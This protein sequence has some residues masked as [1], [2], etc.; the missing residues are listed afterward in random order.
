MKL[1]ASLTSPYARK[2]RVILHEKQLP[3]E[4]VV[5]SPWESNTLIP[6]VNPLGKVPVL[7]TDDEEVY[8]DSPLIAAWLET[9]DAPP[10]L[11]PADRLEALRVQRTEALA[12]GINDAA[13]HAFLESRRPGGERSDAVIARQH[14]KIERALDHLEAQA[15]GHTWLHGDDITLADIAVGIALGY[16]DLRISDL[17]WRRAHPALAGLAER[18]FTRP[19]FIDTLPPAG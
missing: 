2:I 16:L 10:R 6:S 7:I 9:L 3:F 18:L 8:F 12:D 1:F 15:G 5:D 17:D 13:V 11:L 14:A 4:L 19:S